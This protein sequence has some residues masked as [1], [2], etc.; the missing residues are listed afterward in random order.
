MGTGHPSF[1][2]Q[3]RPWNIECQMTLEDKK[4]REKD[5]R[6]SCKRCKTREKDTKT[7]CSA[8]TAEILSKYFNDLT[9]CV[10]GSIKEI[11]SEKTGRNERQ[12]GLTSNHEAVQN[13]FKRVQRKKT[14]SDRKKR[15]GSQ[16]KR[17]GQDGLQ[18]LG[19]GM[20]PEDRS[21]G[22]Q[23]RHKGNIPQEQGQRNDDTETVSQTGR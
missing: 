6:T 21:S 11:I 8:V 5:T 3:I 16:D 4:E 7:R 20:V 13:K 12:S 14:N 2:Q 15:M 9:V 10:Y 17:Y 22:Q 23:R 18:N 1:R 19:D